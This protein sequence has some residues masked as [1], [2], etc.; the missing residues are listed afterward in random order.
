[1]LHK[2]MIHMPGLDDKVGGRYDGNL[3]FLYCTFY[4]KESICGLFDMCLY[5]IEDRTYGHNQVHFGIFLSTK[6]LDHK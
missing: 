4:G 5:G 6:L 2:K 3:F 1:M